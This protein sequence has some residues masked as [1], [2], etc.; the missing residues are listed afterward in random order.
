MDAAANAVIAHRMPGRMR[1]LVPGR[2]ADSEYFS[3]V[4][5]KL[6]QL[7]QVHKAKVNPVTGSITIE[8]SGDAREIE[9]FARR[10]NLFIVQEPGTQDIAGK[11]PRSQPVLNLVSGRQIGPMFIAGTIFAGIGVF[12]TFRGQVLV[13][14]ISAFWYAAEAFRRQAGERT[15]N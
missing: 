12:Q 4:A 3:R 2:R 8:F 15:D 9:E 13:P 1:L 6:A 10:E 5:E 11:R 14:A 7:P